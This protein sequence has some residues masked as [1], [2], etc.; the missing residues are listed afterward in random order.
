[1]VGLDVADVEV[2]TEVV[3]GL[4]VLVGVDVG[5]DEV[6]TEVLEWA[7]VL[8]LVENDIA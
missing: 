1:M 6:D 2:A 4:V 3:E 7:K 5:G 8:V